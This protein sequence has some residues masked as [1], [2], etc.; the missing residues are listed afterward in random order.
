M[1]GYQRLRVSP[2]MLAWFKK[3]G[4][5]TFKSWDFYVAV[6]CGLAAYVICGSKAVRS[7]AVPILIAEA[8]IGVALLAVV[9]GAIAVFATFYDATYRRVLDLAGGFRSALMPYIVVAVIAALAGAVGIISALALPALD[10]IPFKLVSAASTLLCAWAIT[11]MVS[12]TELTL[13]HATERAKLMRGA[14]EA[15]T[16]RAQRLREGRTR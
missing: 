2:K 5:G 1:R 16:I 4:G 3:Y 8:A 13:F 15:E 6:V 7:A 9:F 14:D 10:V 12:I 11:G